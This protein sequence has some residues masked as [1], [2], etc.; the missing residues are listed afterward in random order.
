M[1]DEIDN[2]TGKDAC[3]V[4]GTP[5]WHRKGIVVSEA[6]N[7]EDA[8][9]LALQDWLV[10][11]WPV[12]A[13]SPDGSTTT[14]V[15]NRFALVRSDTHAALGVRSGQYRVFQNQECYD[16]LDSIVGQN[17]AMYDTAGVLRG[18]R[19]VWMLAKIPKEYRIVKGDNVQP[20]V[21]LV[22]NHGTGSLHVFDTAVRVVC[23]NTM[24]AALRG[25]NG[26]ITIPH[27]PNLD[28]RVEEARTALGIV[29]Q[30]L[31][32]FADVVRQM[33][34]TSLTAAG[35]EQF[36]ANLFPTDKRLGEKKI[37]EHQMICGLLLSNLY[38]ERNTLPGIGRSVW[39][40]L[41]AVTEWADYQRPVRGRN[42][43]NR[44]DN[45]LNSVWFGPSDRIK[46][47]AF[48]A[49]LALVG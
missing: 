45:Y 19:K 49:A 9:K 46:Y 20:Y 42:E 35:C 12:T 41:N 1:S 27:W 36:F 34:K 21:L 7:G 2:S 32:Q 30:R 26:G 17:L 6:Q 5:A 33:A 25:R 44:L 38:N 28:S 47:K 3:M 4:V 18:G 31:D 39:A 13:T 29:T 11:K 43:E 10:E 8:R 22:N 24:R 14:R 48:Q 16:F 40:C 37:E 15:A 23:M